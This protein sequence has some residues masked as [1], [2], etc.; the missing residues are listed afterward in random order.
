M[1]VPTAARSLTAAPTNRSGQVRLT[2]LAPSSN[3]GSAVTDYVIQRSPNGTTGWT[4][5]SDGVNTDRLHRRRVGQRHAL[6]LPGLAHNTV[7]NGPT[8]N[9][10]NAIP[11]TLATAARSLTAAPTN[12]SGQVRLT[13]LAPTSNGGSAVT[14]Y[15][16]QRSPNGTSGWTTMS[17]GVNTTTAYTV[18]GLV[19][20]PAT[21]SGSTPTTPPATAPP[22]TSPTP[23]PYGADRRPV[24]D[25]GTDERVGP[26]PSHVAG[27]DLERRV[28]GHR[29]RRPTFAQRHDQLDDDQR[30]RQH[31]HDVHRRRT[32]ERHALLL[33]GLRPQRRRQRSGRQCRQRHPTHG[34]RTGVVRTGHR[35]T[36]TASTSRGATR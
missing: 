34:S 23:S 1:P 20:A 3:G 22:A 14:D 31:Q 4:T 2:W 25:R 6:L 32:G 16:I 9:V 21:T 35:L 19:K 7:G 26:G 24:A 36:P 11:R 17:D 10:A 33:P 28:G 8:S 13:W 18:A 5:I 27:S 15:V 12:R 29:L 30:R